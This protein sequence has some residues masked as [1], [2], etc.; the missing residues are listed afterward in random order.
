MACG[1]VEVLFARP[2]VD[3]EQVID[4]RHNARGSRIAR[5]ELGGLE[6][7]PSRVRP[8]GGMHHLRPAHVIVGAIAVGLQNALELSQKL[9]W[10]VAPPPQAEVEHH[11][12]PRSAVLPQIGLMVLPPPI[13]HL[14]V[15]CR[16]IS[17]NVS[18]S[19]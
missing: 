5:V 18:A 13:V 8:A 2:R 4:S 16:F 9:L 6:E 19:E 17:L 10:P 14:H 3:P 7:L 15:Y 1:V 12:A 11:A